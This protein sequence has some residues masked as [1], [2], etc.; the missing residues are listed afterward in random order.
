[1]D[2]IK[3]NQKAR[4]GSTDS[5]AAELRAQASDLT[6]ARSHGAD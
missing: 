4:P 1:M 3:V 2:S 5:P 6:E